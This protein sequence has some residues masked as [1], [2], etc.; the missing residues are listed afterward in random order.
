M[1]TC[2]SR[3]IRRSLAASYAAIRPKTDLHSV[4]RRIFMERG[5]RGW[6]RGIRRLALET[7]LATADW[8]APGEL[9]SADL[10]GSSQRRCADCAAV[11]RATCSQVRY[12]VRSVALEGVGMEGL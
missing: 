6:R 12:A 2:A 5:F 7:A 10:Q 4:Y 8:G 11:P 9:I 1:L 3:C